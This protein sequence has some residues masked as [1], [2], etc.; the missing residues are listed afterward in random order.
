MN[1]QYVG[2]YLLVAL[3][4]V[5][6]LLIFAVIGVRAVWRKF[7]P[8][9]KPRARD[10]LPQRIQNNLMSLAR[11][12]RLRRGLRRLWEAWCGGWGRPIPAHVTVTLGVSR[13]A[14]ARAQWDAR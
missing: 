1:T 10:L 5:I 2:V 6:P 3:T 11:L 12:K 8:P 7:H 4:F 9:R 13:V 14:L